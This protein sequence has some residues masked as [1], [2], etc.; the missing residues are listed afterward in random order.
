M[1]ITF[2]T[3]DANPASDLKIT[4]GLATLPA[5]WSSPVDSLTCATVSAG[6]AC[7]LTLTY[8]PTV[9][10]VGGALTLDFSYD[11]DSDIPGTGSVT[12]TYS[13]VTPYLF[14][15]NTTGN[16]ISSCPINFD[17]SV[18]GCTVAAT[19]SSP[20]GIA[21]HGS[22]AYIAGSV[23]NAVSR[24]TVAA[25]SLSGCAATGG[26]MVLPSGIALSPSGNFAYVDALAS[27]LVCA[28]SPGDGSLSG[29]MPTGG[30]LNEFGIAL[31]ADGTH[32]YDV[33]V[34]TVGVAPLAISIPTVELC[35]IAAN[36]SVVGCT[37]TGSNAAAAKAVLGIR[38]NILYLSTTTGGLYSCPVNA[39]ATLGSCQSSVPGAAIAGLAF[40]GNTAYL[41]TGS[42][43]LAC[44]IDADGTVS[45]CT[46]VTDPT[47]SGTAG[48]AVR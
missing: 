45:G 36:G 2:T 40:S 35:S 26:A 1:T 31:S 4:S 42:A 39:D 28:V 43:V 3:N 38:N 13:A 27:L 11:N 6:T 44:A 20:E 29:C 47:F 16:S 19:S 34:V 15:A 25:G 33:N 21:L 48:L 12:L 37:A 18:Q 10:A 41:S 14:V 8:A 22:Y 17:D 5:G 7:E 23:L 46:T 30:L 32:A 9:G 24:C